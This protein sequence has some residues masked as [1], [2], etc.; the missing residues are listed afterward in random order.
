MKITTNQ[1][2]VWLVVI[3]IFEPSPG[4]EPGTSSFAYTPI[5]KK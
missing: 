4:I 5:Y 3:F 2:G 1:T